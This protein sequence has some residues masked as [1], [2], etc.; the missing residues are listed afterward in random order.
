MIRTMM[1]KLKT[2]EEQRNALLRSM[3]AYTFAFN[4]SAKWGFENSRITDSLIIMGLI[5]TY[6]I[7]SQY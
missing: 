7:A 5:V 4:V 3:E 1:L 6:V 2:T